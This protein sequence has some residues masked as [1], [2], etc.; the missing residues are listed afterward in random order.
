MA[1][2]EIIKQ[3]V[4]NVSGSLKQTAWMSVL[5][6]LITIILGI[7]LVAFSEK[8][9]GVIAC[10]VGVFLVIKGGY[11]IINYFIVKGQNDFFNN[12]L[13]AGIVSLLIGVAMLAMGEGI[14]N[15]FRIA[16]G[17]WLIYEA[18]VRISTAIKLH[19]AGINVWKYI[20]LLAL[21]TLVV[22]LFVT[23]YEGAVIV[24]VGWMLILGGVIGI[25]CD[26]MFIQYVNTLVEKLTDTKK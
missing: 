22:G 24:L 25:I 13:L 1:K 9:V 20:L 6:S 18:L 21:C 19:A 12:S 3:P 16:I 15:V 2:A 14:I 23:F 7:L 5:E 8:I 11:Q 26:T 17:I 4:E 10:I